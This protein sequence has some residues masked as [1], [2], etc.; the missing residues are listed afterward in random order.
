MESLSNDDLMRMQAEFGDKL[1]RV[2]AEIARKAIKIVVPQREAL[3]DL[4]SLER[5][6]LYRLLKPHAEAALL[7][8]M[9]TDINCALSGST[10]SSSLVL[11]SDA[12][13]V[14]FA[15][16]FVDLF[17]P[18]IVDFAFFYIFRYV[19]IFSNTYLADSIKLAQYLKQ[20]RK[21]TWL[22]LT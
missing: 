16:D 9:L 14:S 8:M 6:T 17:Q 3:H 4:S 20:M 21:P 5:K 7:A 15:C 2:E 22:V 12:R 1:E 11:L 18:S 19:M 10:S 13:S